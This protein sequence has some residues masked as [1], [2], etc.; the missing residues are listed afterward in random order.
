MTR[1]AVDSGR[2]LAAGTPVAVTRC[3]A[4]APMT[5][6][7]HQTAIAVYASG[8]TGPDRG[9]QR[10]VHER[11]RH[12]PDESAN[13]H[14]PQTNSERAEG[15]GGQRVGQTGHE[16]PS[17]H[18]PQSAPPDLVV[19][20]VGTLRTQ[21]GAGAV[22]AGPPS[23]QAR[24]YGGA[25][26]RGQRDERAEDRP[27]QEA[28]PAARIDRVTKTAPSSAETMAKASGAAG[29]VARIMSRMSSTLMTRCTATDR[30]APTGN[31]RTAPAG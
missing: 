23:R 28:L 17:D 21:Q 31:P 16:P 12:R 9:A 1:A 25:D 30:T 26:R 3:A 18:R 11:P 8:L 15:V 10:G 29:P 19:E 7:T 13:G 24:H 6:V 22:P 2:P 27:E 5:A 14:L 4:N 20:P